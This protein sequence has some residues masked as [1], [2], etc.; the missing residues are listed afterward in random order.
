MSSSDSDGEEWIPYKERDEWKD[1]EPVR[2]D[3]GPYPVV[4]IAYSEKFRDV[5]DYFRAIVKLDERSERALSLTQDA[6]LLNPANYSVWHYRREILKSL[7]KD[8]KH[9]LHYISNVIKN[10]AKNYQVWYH[11]G[12][13]VS[14][15]DDP[16][17]ELEFTAE[18]L[19]KDA[20][21]YHA[22][23]HRQAMV[24]DFNMWD[25]E[26]AFVSTLLEEDVRNNSAWNHRY[27]TVMNTS[28]FTDDIAQKELTYCFERIQKTPNNESSWNYAK[29]I[30]EV[31][32]GIE[33]WQE[34]VNLVYRMYQNNT[35]SPYLLSFLLDYY[36]EIL[37]RKVDAETVKIAV[38]LCE[39][40][41]TDAD[42]IR[43]NYWNYRSRCIQAKPIVASK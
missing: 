31:S 15:L 14:W 24:S 28:G 8:L 40:L 37:E 9:E 12:I 41:A 22:W 30:F 5:Y 23:Q 29:G 1:V 4:A 27:Y 38:D 19:R 34:F 42:C 17:K 33:K 16:S 3:D 26:L 43:K 35:D 11:R 13:I 36:E 25:N 2:Q 39:R 21:N 7:N 10:Q 32:G 20:K 6:I 18:I